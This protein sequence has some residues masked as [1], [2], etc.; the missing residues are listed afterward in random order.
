MRNMYY[1]LEDRTPKPI[2]D[3]REWATWFEK[4]DRHVKNDFLPNG[5]HVSTVFLGLD[6]AWSNEPP[7]LFETMIFGSEHDGYQERYSTWEEAE[8]GHQRAIEMVFEVQ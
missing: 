5:I 1:I 3:V 8:A 6:H 7:M 2:T 4:A